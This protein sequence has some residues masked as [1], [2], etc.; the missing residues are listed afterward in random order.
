VADELGSETAPA[1]SSPA[2]GGTVL[3]GR[4]GDDGGPV[5]VRCG[6]GEVL[7]VVGPPGSGRTTAL[8]LAVP[9]LGGRA[10][11]VTDPG[12]IP[13]G[14]AV[15]VLDDVDRWPSAALDELERKLVARPEL[16]VVASARPEPVVGAYRGPLSTWR[17]TASLL[18]LRP[19][20]ATTAQLTDVDLTTASDPARPLHPGRGVLVAR[21]R[22]VAVQVATPASTPDSGS[23]PSLQTTASGARVPEA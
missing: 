13:A 14:P 15:L 22:A 17:A 3:L 10:V 12:D 23:S 4:G 8:M 5:Q 2:N 19:S 20:H 11:T 1:A 7:L 16:A 18:I 9:Q 21:G 6:P